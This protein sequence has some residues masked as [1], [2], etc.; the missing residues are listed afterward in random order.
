MIFLTVKIIQTDFSSVLSQSTRLT[1]GR[2]DTCLA[3]RPTAFTHFNA[4]RYK[5]RRNYCKPNTSAVGDHDWSL[6]YLTHFAHPSPNFYRGSNVSKFWLNF[7][8]CDTPFWNET[9]YL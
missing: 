3:T 1:D 7:G 9:T 8:L 2:T 6:S 4:T 5:K